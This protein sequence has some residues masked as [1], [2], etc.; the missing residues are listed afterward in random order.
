MLKTTKDK[1][2]LSLLSIIVPILM[3][4]NLSLGADHAF[5][6]VTAPTSQ[7]KLAPLSFTLK[8]AV[9]HALANN[10]DLQIAI[11]RIGHAEAQLGIALSAF[12][13]QIT[14]R[15][16]YEHSNNPAQVFSMIL[17]QRDFNANSIQDINNPGYRQNF[18]PEIVGKLSL[19]RGGQDYHHSKAAEL[20]ID[21]A[22]FERS[23]VHNALIE[24]VTISYYTYL[25]A[26]EAQKVAQDSIVAITS[27]L[28]QTKLR[29]EAGTA[30]KSDVLSLEVKLAETQDAEIRAANSIELSKTSI[31]NLLG[32][33]SNQA[34]T[35]LSPS[36][37][38]I[39]PKLT[40]SFSN[41][42]ALALLERPEI[43]AAAKQ[44]QIREHQLKIERGAY[45]PKA[46]AFVSYGQNSQHPGFSGQRDNVTV[47][48]A[49]EMNLFSGFNTKQRISAAERKL[50][51][52]RETERK[53]RLAIEQEVKIAFLKL[54]EALARLRVT[55]AS[56]RA[57]DEALR[58]V[59][60]ERRAGMVTVT[61]Y[62]ESEV[63]KNK[64]QSNSIAAHYD[65]LNAE[66]ALKKAI[67]DWK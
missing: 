28:N 7:E 24:A 8:Q 52:V 31:A 26:L 6:N 9:D 53:T 50:A 14:A 22:E 10:P 64:A 15:A 37:I 4:S 58:L 3:L 61:R 21:A 23:S 36:S 33:P 42:L 44:V 56:V 60:E 45:L 46:D 5:Q 39:K 65:A 67:G 66:T 1:L 63:A 40:D 49:V 20:G 41:L 54:E 35:I 2:A 30:L 19:F 43:K 34:F 38:L 47:G 48:V 25:A 55:E 18:R 29:Y 27:E 51:E 13:P 32:L 17:S 59:N 57:A 62:I 11:E 12:Y 16:S